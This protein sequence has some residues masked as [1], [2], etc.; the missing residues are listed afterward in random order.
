MDICEANR[1]AWN[2][3]SERRNYWTLMVSGERIS[4]AKQGKPGIWVTP[5]KEVPLSWI[6][7]L[8]G[9]S[10]LLACG[11]GGQQTPVLAAY[12]CNVTTID[13]SDAQIE[14]DR[15]SLDRY[16][17]E[18]NLIRGNVLEM[19]FEDESFDAVIM[20]QAM[21]F[22][23][24]LGL[25]YSQIHRVLKEGGRFIFGTANPV[26]YTF[27]EKVQ[28]HRL[29]MKYTIPFSHTRSFSE[30]ELERRVQNNDTLEFSHTLDS[31]I[32][33]LTKAGFVIDGFYSDDSGSELT[34][35]FVC[36]SQLAF[37]AIRRQ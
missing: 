36:D 4:A 20:P 25:L 17:L 35:S 3:E 24:D 2:N 1:K 22:I 21:N 31:I 29:R 9:R 23:E 37:K 14:Q 27:D 5:F 7:D 10:V 33:G 30:K 12:G 19:P 28:E 26:I 11:G 6:E 16:G 15:A 32:G 13:I 34:D 8:K 18:A